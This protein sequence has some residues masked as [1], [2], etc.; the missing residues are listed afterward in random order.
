[1]LESGKS[2]LGPETHLIIYMHRKVIKHRIGAWSGWAISFLT[3]SKL[4]RMALIYLNLL[5]MVGA[6][7]WDWVTSRDPFQP[8]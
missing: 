5:D 1:M 8:T 7:T 6:G 2:Q 4:S 3:V